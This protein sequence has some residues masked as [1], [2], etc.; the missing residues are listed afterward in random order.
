MVTRFLNSPAVMIIPVYRSSWVVFASPCTVSVILSREAGPDEGV[1]EIQGSSQLTVQSRLAVKTTVAP[2]LPSALIS[3]PSGPT[4]VTAASFWQDAEKR[5]VRINDTR[6]RLIRDGTDHE[7]AVSVIIEKLDGLFV[8]Q[9]IDTHGDV[10][11]KG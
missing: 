2:L 1:N 8:G 7:N 5:T 3:K 11:V 6:M 9:D 10:I 4:S